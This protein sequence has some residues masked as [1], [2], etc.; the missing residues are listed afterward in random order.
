[1]SFLITPANVNDRE[2]LKISRSDKI[3][4][5]KISVNETVN[6]ELKNVSLWNILNT[7][8]LSFFFNLIARI[9]AY[10]FLPKKPTIRY[11]RVQN[12]QLTFL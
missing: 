3:L 2:P 10:H 1:M 7:D 9:F 11:E 4:P 8:H 6:N 12:N 5:R